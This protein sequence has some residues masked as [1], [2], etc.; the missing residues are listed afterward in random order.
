MTIETIFA[1]V[2]AV[3]TGI[4]G[5]FFKNRIVPSRFI[6][7]QNIIIGIIAAIIA[8]YFGL[9]NDIPTAIIMSLAISMGVGG[10][11]DA[12]QICKKSNIY[13]TKKK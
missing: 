12:T 5:A 11:Y 3:I 8:V 1:V 2:T 13:K 6:P 4:L 9:F 10:T 7:L